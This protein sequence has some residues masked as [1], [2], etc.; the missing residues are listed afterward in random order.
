MNPWYDIHVHTSL[1]ECCSDKENQRPEKLLG[2]AED[3]GLRLIGFSDH[4]W[5]NPEIKPN[6]WYEPQNSSRILAMRNNLPFDSEGI[7]ILVGCEGETI[8]PGKF[9]VTRYLVEKLDF[10]LLAC[11]HFQI[12]DFV[13]QPSDTTPRGVAKHVLEFFMSAVESGLATAIPH[14]MLPIGYTAI[15]DEMLESISNGELYDAFAAASGMNVA[16]EVTLAFFPPV[17]EGRAKWSMETP[18]R[19]LGIARQAGCKFTFASDAHKPD[20]FRSLGKIAQLLD[21]AGISEKDMLVNIQ[22]PTS[23]KQ[24]KD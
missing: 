21:A 20:D 2:I 7:R 17:I 24:P 9:G 8:A 19:L 13:A 15:F 18:I 23:N 14:P 12:S 16:I 5:D 1:S 11:S 10:C 6:F 4:V 3:M 22:R